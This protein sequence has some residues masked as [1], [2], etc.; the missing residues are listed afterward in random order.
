M[1]SLKELKTFIG[2]QVKDFATI[3]GNNN[4]SIVFEDNT[5]LK[6][7]DE[8]VECGR[9]QDV[10]P[11]KEENPKKERK[12]VLE[13]INNGLNKLFLFLK[14]ILKIGFILLIIFI[15]YIVFIHWA[16]ISSFFSHL[17]EVAKTWTG[18]V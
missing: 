5:I 10:G 3:N 1:V 6:F 2:K 7:T 16:D 9:V 17:W 8:P 12:P 11:S 15:G 13:T 14:I 4:F 18:A